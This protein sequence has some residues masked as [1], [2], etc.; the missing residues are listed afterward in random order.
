MSAADRVLSR[1]EALPTLGGATTR[2]GKSLKEYSILPGFGLSLGLTLTYTSLVVLLPLAGLFLRSSTLGWEAFWTAVL[3]PRVLAS[4]RLSFGAAF[5][6]ASVNAVF[7]MVVA[8]T[9]T[10]YRFPGRRILDALVDLPFAL[11][12][13]VSGIA[14]TTLFVPTG[15]FGSRLA[16]LGIEV[17][18]TKL[19]I[20]IALVLIGLPFVVRTLQPAIEDLRTEVEE[21]AATLGARRGYI[22]LRIVLPSLLPALLTGFALAF[23]RGVGEYGSVIFIA[24]N[25]PFETEITPLLI[26]IRLEQYDYAGAAAIGT[27]MLVVSFLLLLSINLLQHW[28]RRRSGGR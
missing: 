8:W 25:M 10:R 15:W 16:P 2:S 23:A 19:G 28:S 6:A 17:A 20:V 12:T 13:A 11:P 9:L 22:F 18:F 3:D 24:G 1:G 7:G 14:L 26:M 21:A 4:L 27:V 5:V